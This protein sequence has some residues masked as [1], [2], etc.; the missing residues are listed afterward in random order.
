VL[1]QQKLEIEIVSTRFKLQETHFSVHV[2]HCLSATAFSSEFFFCN[3]VHDDAL[4][5]VQVGA[6]VKFSRGCEF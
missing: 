6:I 3:V 2:T 1:K 4:V 5:L